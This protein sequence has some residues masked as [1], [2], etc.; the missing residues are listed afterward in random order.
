V[1]ST[2]DALG[3]K[4]RASILKRRRQRRELDDAQC[5]EADTPCGGGDG[6]CVCIGGRRLFGAP[7]G[8]SRSASTGGCVCALNPS[9]PP[10]PSVPSPSPPPRLPIVIINA[11]MED[12]PSPNC[13]VNTGSNGWSHTTNSTGGTCWLLNGYYTGQIGSSPAPNGGLQSL[14]LM[15]GCTSNQ[16]GVYQDLS[17]FVIGTRYRL[18]WDTVGGSWSAQA[19]FAFATMANADRTLIWAQHFYTAASHSW[20]TEAMEFTAATAEGRVAFETMTTSSCVQIDNVAIS[21]VD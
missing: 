8:G 21:P 13:P 4:K 16:G 3:K 7:V 10:S 19:D 15:N 9:P 5:E 17:G 12:V 20:T 11:G 6:I 14:H 1:A 18:S 2:K